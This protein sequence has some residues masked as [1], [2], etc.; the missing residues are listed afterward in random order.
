MM[1]SSIMDLAPVVGLT[2]ASF[3]R[4]SLQSLEGTLNHLQPLCKVMAEEEPEPGLKRLLTEA[5]GELERQY[6]VLE[7][8][9]ERYYINTGE[10]K[11]GNQPGAAPHSIST[12]RAA[13]GRQA[14]QHLR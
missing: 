13:S 9:R 14:R 6:R 10:Q 4:R 5:R 7:M 8:L 12:A 3:E 2:G 1:R 11:A